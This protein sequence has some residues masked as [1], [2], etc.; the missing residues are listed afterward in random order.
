MEQVICWNDTGKQQ[1][2]GAVTMVEATGTATDLGAVGTLQT[3]DAPE[4]AGAVTL[5]QTRGTATDAGAVVHWI[6]ATRLID[7]RT[8]CRRQCRWIDTCTTAGIATDAGA[9][10]ALKVLVAT[11]CTA[12]YAGAVAK[13]GTELFQR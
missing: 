10:T 7:F 8:S 13:L 12:T 5:V 4:T 9:V 2:A 6:S 1:T 11:T 3:S